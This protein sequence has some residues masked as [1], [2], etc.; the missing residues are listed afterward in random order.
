[1]EILILSCGTGGG[2]NTAALAIAEEARRRGHTVCFEDAF[3]LV[4][5]KA[6]S[7]VNSTYIKTVQYLPRVFGAVYFLGEAYSKHLSR[8]PVYWANAKCAGALGAYLREHRFDAVIATH[9]FPA[10]MLTALKRQGVLVPISYLVATDYTC[11]PF[12]EEADC[13]Y[14]VIPAKALCSSFTDRGID[15]EKLLPFGIPVKAAFCEP[16]S[17]TEACHRLG[18]SAEPQYILLT[19][20]SMGASSMVDSIRILLPFL[21]CHPQFRLIVVCGSNTALYDR[22]RTEYAAFSQLHIVAHTSH[23]ADYMKACRV[24]ITKPGGLS[25]TEAA[26]CGVPLVHMPPIPGCE[27]YNARFFEQ[28]GMSV[29]VSNP[30]TMLT[31][32]LCR[33]LQSETAKAMTQAQYRLINRRAASDL[34]DHMEI[35]RR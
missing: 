29:A 18:L 20:G 31:S 14:V 12:M 26:V 19:G 7:I 30:K 25:T 23:M 4:G 9:L 2:H 13:D 15:A 6:A 27:S 5:E 28:H 16:L 11:H 10:H 32:A 24:F 21:Q 34:C 35:H 1:M 33:V 3:R 22:L 8:S 17:E